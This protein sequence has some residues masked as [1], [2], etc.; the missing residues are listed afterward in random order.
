MTECKALPL[1]SG[2]DEGRSTFSQLKTNKLV[3]SEEKKLIQNTY[4]DNNTY[5]HVVLFESLSYTERGIGRLM[6]K[7]QYSYRSKC[8]DIETI[9]DKTRSITV[10]LGVRTFQKGR[11]QNCCRWFAR[12]SRESTSGIASGV[13]VQC[14]TPTNLYTPHHTVYTFLLSL[15]V[16]LFSMKFL[17]YYK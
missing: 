13:C 14:F 5:F 12:F 1:Q 9:S 6:L 4:N 11:A 2:D 7:L 16:L 15:W 10:Y 17:K 8:K 3:H